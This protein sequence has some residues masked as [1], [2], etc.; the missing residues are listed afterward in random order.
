MADK[1]Y[2]PKASLKARSTSFGEVIRFNFHAKTFVEWL[3]ENK[4]HINDKGYVTI[5]ILPRKEEGN[6]GETHNA[7][8]DT[9]KPDGNGGGQQKTKPA[10]PAKKAAPAKQVSDADGFAEEDIPF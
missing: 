6:Y 7:I 9:W 3:R 1:I 10:A 5:D 4:D 2:V 8:L